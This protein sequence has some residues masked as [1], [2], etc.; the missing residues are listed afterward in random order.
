M[1]KKTR[2]RTA[3]SSILLRKIAREE[4]KYYRGMGLVSK[5]KE[6]PLF[7]EDGSVVAL[8]SKPYPQK[9]LSRFLLE[10]AARQAKRFRRRK[11]LVYK[12]KGNRLFVDTDS[13]KAL[14]P[15]TSS[16]KVFKIGEILEKVQGI[17]L[18]DLYY[19]VSESFIT[20]NI[21]KKRR[22]KRLEFAES[23]FH[24]IQIMAKHYRLGLPPR[25]C[26]ERYLID[27]ELEEL[28]DHD[29]TSENIEKAINKLNKVICKKYPNSREYIKERI[30]LSETGL[31][32]EAIQTWVQY[33]EIL[34]QKTLGVQSEIENILALIR[35]AVESLPP[36]N[37][38]ACMLFW[39]SF[40]SLE[41]VDVFSLA[42]RGF[43]R[44]LLIDEFNDSREQITFF[45]SKRLG[46]PPSKVFRYIRKL[47]LD[48]VDI[49]EVDIEFPSEITFKYEE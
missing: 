8:L 39:V 46:I 3:E 32:G 22:L 36:R 49:D 48:Y 9:V 7:G 29:S 23:E 38:I 16:Q 25:F 10:K 47:F 40:E 31:L 41:V 34:R 35:E 44:E 5:K 14:L 17:T 42:T 20:P 21:I 2:V 18:R 4:R 11:S 24:K 26:Y 27:L 19:W 12:K 28:H 6:S 1:T 13:V 43:E 37:Q 15:E 33:P 45:L 30:K